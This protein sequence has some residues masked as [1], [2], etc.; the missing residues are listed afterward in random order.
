MMPQMTTLKHELSPR[1][2]HMLEKESAIAPH[3]IESRGYWTAETVEELQSDPG[4]KSN[5]HFAPALIL[6]VYGVDGE[7]KYSRVRPDE[8]PAHLG[9][10]IQP[11]GTPNVLD[12]PRAVRNRVLDANYPLAATEGERKAD[13]L[14]SLGYAVICLVGVWNWSDKTYEDTPYESQLLLPDFDLIPLRG[15]KVS[16]AFDCDFAINKNVELAAYRLAQKLRE[17][18]AELW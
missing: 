15:R 8:P 2:R 7:Y 17:R 1:H 10:Y 14:A 5:Q 13:Y 12:V 18:G 6:P 4:I 3:V 16:I 11:A 9:K